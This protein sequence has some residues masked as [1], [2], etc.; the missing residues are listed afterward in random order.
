MINIASVAKAVAVGGEW[1]VLLILS[2]A[3]RGM[4]ILTIAS[5][6]TI[7]LEVPPSTRR[8]EILLPRP[9]SVV[10]L[11]ILLSRLVSARLDI[12]L[13]TKVTIRVE[14]SL[15]VTSFPSRVEVFLASSA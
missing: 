9:F 10:R 5:C 8:M 11:E 6:S 1:D 13:L 14:I 2:S 15:I 7:I 12:M 4:V 3:T